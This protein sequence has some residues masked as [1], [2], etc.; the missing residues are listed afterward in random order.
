MRPT[1]V[2]RLRGS[3]GLIRRP[4]RSSRPEQSLCLFRKNGV[5]PLAHSLAVCATTLAVA[6]ALLSGGEKAQAAT[7]FW[8][9]TAANTYLWSTGS[10]WS[11]LGIPGLADDT[12]NF[13]NAILG[14]QTVNLDGVFTVGTLNVGDTSSTNTFTIGATG[15]LV[16]DVTGGSAQINKS[17]NGL[18]SIST[19]IQFNDTLAITNSATSGTLTLSGALRSLSSDLTLNGTGAVS[20]GSVVISGVISTAGNLVKNDAGVA[21][22]TGPN[23]YAGTT[24]VNNG[25]LVLNNIA[26]LPI[27]SAVTIGS[28]ATVDAQQALTLGS[29]AGAG[30]LRNSTGTARIL[31]V[32]RDETST[33]FSGRINPT[34]AANVALTKVGTGTLTLRPSGSNASTYTG[35]TV[36]NGGKLVLD[37][38]NSSLTS[39]F[40]GVTPLQITGGNFEMLG[41]SGATV[42]QTLG[43]LTVGATGGGITL[44][45]NG[46][47]ST[48]LRIGSVT[49]S[50][51][52]G[53]LL[54][55]APTG[56]A[57]SNTTTGLTSNVL[58]A[59]RIVF[60][61]GAG[62][63][64]WLSQGSATPFQWTGLGTGVGTTPN[65]TG[66]LPS[67][68]SGV[69]AGNYT[70]SG[71]QTQST[72]PSTIYTLKVSSTAASQS[73]DLSTFNLSANGILV[74]GT[75]AY[76]ISG[77]GALS[78]TENIIHQ[79]NSGGLTVNAGI[80]GTTFTKA[81]TGTLTIG[82]A[83]TYTGVTYVNG[84]TLSFSSVAA[85]GSGTLGLGIA[86]AVQIRDGATLQYTGV[87]GTL[88]AGTTANSH[89]YSLPGGNANI[90]V[91]Q[92]GTELTLSG[93]ISGAGGYTKLGPGTLTIGASSTFTGPLFINAGT[94][95]AGGNFQIGSGTTPVTV[96]SG[97]VLDIN[98][99]G[100][101]QTLTIGSL[102]GSGTITNSN[103]T[104]KTLSI[105]GDN[106]STTFSGTFAAGSAAGSILTKTGTG[107]FTLT[108]STSGWTGGNNVN[109]GVLRLGASNVLSTTGTTN[110]ALAAG[111]AA[112]ELSPGVSQQL[113]A[114]TFYGSGTAATSQ[115][116]VLIGTGGLPHP[117]WKRDREQHQQPPRRGGFRAWCSRPERGVRFFGEQKHYRS[118]I[119]LRVDGEHARDWGF[120]GEQDRCRQPFA[121]RK[122]YVCRFG[123]VQLGRRWN[124]CPFGRQQRVDEHD[125]AQ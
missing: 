100:T 95:K 106:T 113:A 20:T 62:A 52:G 81:G 96:A 6:G 59:G 47:T 42:T 102:S 4:L 75:D 110:I 48:T 10:N 108:G 23:T 61:D 115:G 123:C 63:F 58:G 69:A 116:N 37:T 78:A 53:A 16:L 83:A 84:G 98:G 82:G 79:Y 64:N 105:G 70:V 19:G 33:V 97:A 120:C 88:A 104:A 32:G 24:S 8:Q 12:V 49:A 51:A 14:N 68:G 124:H 65:Y 54:V 39:G 74:T 28:G 11:P 86:Q 21:S 107:I 89:I 71:S 99:T 3:A 9:P 118:V 109:G 5:R 57:V 72:A 91:T 125:H 25:T 114:L 103:T 2:P 46:G 18:D 80:G 66:T 121:C 30:D 36:L 41:R 43:N 92:A 44:T 76:T 111:P 90:E 94:L 29:L 112:L 77:T 73:L 85:S 15:Y 40:L 13:T 31:T 122:Q 34:T 119:R 87:S 45:P 56:T 38:S 17:G 1:R 27:R 67:N 101:S 35:N 22:L 50:A 7:Y 93:V 55:T 117:W 60:S 26:A